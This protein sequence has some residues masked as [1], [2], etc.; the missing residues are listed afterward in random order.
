[1]IPLTPILL[2]STV[3]TGVI[4][5][6]LPIRASQIFNF[7]A[8]FGTTFEEYRIVRAQIKIQNFSSTNSG[9]FTHW[10]DEKDFV[11]APTA[12]E[13]QQKSDRRFSCASPSPHSLEWRARDPL[14]LQYI[15]IG[16][17]STILAAYKIYTD[18]P[19]FGSSPVVTPYAEITGKFWI[20]F[21][22]WN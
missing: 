13:A 18:S 21:R 9:V 19:N 11:T 1:M 2:T 7:A 8:R 6:I 10:I 14:D 4:S 17:S 16:T 20:Q 22:G 12:A 15:D 5:T 3:T